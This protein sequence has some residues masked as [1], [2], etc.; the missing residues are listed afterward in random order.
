MN[1]RF[2]DSQRQFSAIQLLQTVSQVFSAR[3]F[4]H[5][6]V[7]IFYLRKQ[8]VLLWAREEDNFVFSMQKLKLKNIPVRVTSVIWIAMSSNLYIMKK[9]GQRLTYLF[10]YC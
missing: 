10:K 8:A 2:P 9:A 1:E 4:H 5:I 7:L 3:K 6:V